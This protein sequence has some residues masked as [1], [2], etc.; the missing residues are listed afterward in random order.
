MLITGIIL[1]LFNL[2]SLAIIVYCLMSWFPGALQTKFGYFLGR[3]VNPFLD[4]F[5]FIPPIFN[6]DFSPVI[7]LIALQLVEQGLLF[8]IKLLFGV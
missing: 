6:I 5:H 8:L 4:I 1:G 3:I 7:A 2:Y